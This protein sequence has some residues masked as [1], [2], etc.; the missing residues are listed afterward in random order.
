MASVNAEHPFAGLLELDVGPGD[1]L[2]IDD[3]FHRLRLG[4]A[5]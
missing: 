4:G 1:S 2:Q 5:T 3:F